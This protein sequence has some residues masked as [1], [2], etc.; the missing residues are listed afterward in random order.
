MIP[1]R[2]GLREMLDRDIPDV[3]QHIQETGALDGPGKQAILKT[4]QNYVRTLTATAETSKAP[5][6]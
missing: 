1:F 6:P 3:V 5:Q 4:L 2:Q